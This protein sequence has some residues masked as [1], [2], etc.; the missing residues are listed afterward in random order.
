MTTNSAVASPSP[1]TTSALT[2]P[3][4]RRVEQ[5]DDYFGAT[6]SDP[7]RWM[8]DVDS[9]ELKTWV[10]AENEVTQ[11]YL[12]QVP[13]RETMQRRLMELINFERYT[14]PASWDSLFLLAQQRVAE[15]E[16]HLLAGRS[17]G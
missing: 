2:Y 6:V 14:A 17:G 10:D 8:E 3:T 16:C 1:E 12:S 15:S 9:S 11:A 13:S 5:T 4:A 7:Y